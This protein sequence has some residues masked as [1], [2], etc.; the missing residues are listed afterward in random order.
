[1]G[2]KVRRWAW[3]AGRLVGILAGIAMATGVFAAAGY[4]IAPHSEEALTPISR[5]RLIVD[6][7]LEP[8][9][10]R[11]EVYDS[12]GVQ[13]G[14]LNTSIDRQIIPYEQI[15][16][17]VIEAVTAVEDENFFEHNGWDF[18]GTLRALMSNVSAGGISQG[19][20]TITQQIVKLRVVGPE[21]TLNR[22]I[23]EAVLASRL[24]EELSKE[25]LLEFYLNEIYFGNGAYGIQAAAETY[26]GKEAQEL[27]HGDAALLAGLI[28]APSIFDGFDDIDIAQRRREVGLIRLLDQGHITEEEFDEYQRRPLPTRNLSPRFTDETLRRNYFLD[29]VTDAALDLEVLGETRD[30]RFNAVYA[31]GLRIYST[32][33]PEMEQMM[34]ASVEEFFADKD[35]GQFEVSIA[36]IEPST[37]AIRAFIGGPDFADF[38]FNLATQG[39]RQP[40]S[41]FKT[42]VLTTAVERAGFLPYDTISGIGPCVF[43]DGAQGFYT[44]N[45]FGGGR[46]SA[47]TIA[48]MTRASS[49]CAYVRLGILAG[50]DQVVDVASRMIGRTGDDRFLPFKSMSLG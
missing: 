37:G 19:G 50:L 1:M 29:S 7:N 49:N 18:R 4:A 20:S 40:G 23:R 30:E 26:F 27:D 41:S 22:K 39:K 44:V 38:E 13:M 43:D 35:Q 45:N 34:R 16:T 25:E 3:R 8:G 2:V 36:T 15:P 33:D 6:F 46:G 9:E 5:E 42:Y 17:A 47:G 14:V 24:E 32:Y 10:Q 28:R 31:G 12:R 11:T 48:S 21:R